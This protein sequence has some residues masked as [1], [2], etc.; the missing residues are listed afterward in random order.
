LCHKYNREFNKDE[1]ANL[2]CTIDK[3]GKRP[4]IGNSGFFANTTCSKEPLFH[5]TPAQIGNK[6][7]NGIHNADF[8]YRH[9]C[10][11]AAKNITGQ[12]ILDTDVALKELSAVPLPFEKTAGD[13]CFI[14]LEWSYQ[15]YNTNATPGDFVCH[16]L[17]RCAYLPL[18]NRSKINMGT[19]SGLVRHDVPCTRASIDAMKVP[20]IK[21]VL[22]HRYLKNFGGQPQDGEGGAPDAS[23]DSS[24]DG[25]DGD[26]D[27]VQ[28][29]YA[30]Q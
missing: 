11:T 8:M 16:C 26:I 27:G 20:R 30:K 5:F 6:Q 14:P 23:S 29:T 28:G 15:K 4:A 17:S 7:G 25:D 18:K 22:M 12:H 2:V 10:L 3:S 13:I 9:K 21:K 24:G 1:M 19:K